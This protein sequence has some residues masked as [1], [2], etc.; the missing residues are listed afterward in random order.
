MLTDATAQMIAREQASEQTRCR[1]HRK[2]RE[3]SE[4]EP[5]MLTKMAARD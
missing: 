2:A 5:T 1:N 4:A 3:A